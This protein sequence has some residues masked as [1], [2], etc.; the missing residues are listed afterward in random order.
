MIG[1]RYGPWTNSCS[2]T[3]KVTS[4]GSVKGG[5]Q[6]RVHCVHAAL[7]LTMGVD[8]SVD[9]FASV[10][11]LKRKRS[12]AVLVALS[13][14][15][16]ACSATTPKRED[17][18]RSAPH[19]H[20]HTPTHTHTILTVRTVNDFVPLGLGRVIGVCSRVQD[21]GVVSHERVQRN[22]GAR[23]KLGRQTLHVPRTCQMCVCVCVC[24]CARVRVCTACCGDFE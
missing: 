15:V 1:T 9:G 11:H 5:G 20:A 3:K 21:V 22:H 23:R 18:K 8:G 10:R 19:T 17:T 2:C 4:T 13:S 6:F 16:L 24:V 7:S 12:S 14:S